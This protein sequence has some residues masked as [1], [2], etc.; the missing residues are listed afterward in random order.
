LRATTVINSAN[1]AGLRLTTCDL[2]TAVLRFSIDRLC[3]FSAPLIDGTA[4]RRL[5]M[6]SRSTP[7][8]L[9]SGDTAASPKG[10]GI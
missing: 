8:S 4:V 2:L 3:P 5:M 6:Q 10:N 7:T 1:H 9:S